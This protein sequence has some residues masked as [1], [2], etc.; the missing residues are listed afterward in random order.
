MRCIS[1][2]RIKYPQI[3]IIIANISLNYFWE[4]F[5]LLYLIRE[6]CVERCIKH[7]IAKLQL[8][9]NEKKS[10]RKEQT[11]YQKMN[12]LKAPTPF[13]A[14]S[15]KI[16]AFDLDG[17][18]ITTKSKRRFPKDKDDWKLLNEMVALKLQNLH[19]GGYTIVVF[20]NQKN[21]E[22]RMSKADFKE[23]CC[24]IQEAIGV[25]YDLLRISRK[26]V[27]A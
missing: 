26:W 20:T 22:K 19:K 14:I 17:T 8:K 15:N 9:L 16:A 18:L 1:F 7:R 23:K 24:N 12:H 11:R 6:L 4:K 5:H 13:G 25:P 27:Y 3:A 10:G 2:S 21:L